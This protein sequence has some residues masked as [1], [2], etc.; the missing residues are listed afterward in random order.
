M[1]RPT[2]ALR[3]LRQAMERPDICSTA[4]RLLVSSSLTRACSAYSHI[5]AAI[6]PSLHAPTTPSRA[7]RSSQ[8]L[9]T[10]PQNALGSSSPR[11][12]CPDRLSHRP[13]QTRA[14]ASVQPNYSSSSAAR[15]S[16]HPAPRRRSVATTTTACR[17]LAPACTTRRRTTISRLLCITSLRLATDRDIGGSAQWMSSHLSKSRNPT[18]HRRRSY[19][20]KFRSMSRAR[21]QQNILSTSFRP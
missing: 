5:C 12:V 8:T 17:R 10:T 9:Q 6:Q 15:T 1:R 11:S 20:R 21:A 19:C 14:N 7:S 2:S 18:R 4:S 16:R 13:P 3:H